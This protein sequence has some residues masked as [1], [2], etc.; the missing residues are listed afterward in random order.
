MLTTP[1]T[2]TAPLSTLVLMDIVGSQERKR[3][4]ELFMEQGWKQ[5]E[6]AKDL[7][8]KDHS[9][10]NKYLRGRQRVSESFLYKLSE[11]PRYRVSVKFIKS[12]VGPKLL[13]KGTGNAVHQE[14]ETLQ[15]ITLPYLPVPAR[16][17]FAEMSGSEN[18]YGFPE[19][20]TIIRD[21]NENYNENCVIEVNGDSMEPYYP[22][23]TK[24]RCAPVDRS[25]WQYINSGVFA[26]SYA[27]SFVIKRIKN[28]DF[29]KGYLMLH[30][31]NTETGGSVQVPIEQIRSILKVL[32]VVDGPAR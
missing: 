2:P 10:I 32:R 7:G 20:W 9:V 25:N 16:A 28:N 6:V 8:Y 13:L 29:H 26:V 5:A 4:N 31:D 30:S 14:S 12:G 22:S 19:T 15:F 24:V 23:G 11:H 1:N 27:G 18:E 21:P 17:T 3:L